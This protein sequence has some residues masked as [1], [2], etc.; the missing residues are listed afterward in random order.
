MKMG[1]RLGVHTAATL[2]DSIDWLGAAR[3]T[4][5]NASVRESETN[6]ILVDEVQV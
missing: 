1:L 2:D 4:L 3:A 6:L 5:A